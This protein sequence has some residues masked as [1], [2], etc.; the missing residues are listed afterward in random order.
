MIEAMPDL[1]T[2][3]FRTQQ[4]GIALSFAGQDKSLEEG[5]LGRHS[6]FSDVNRERP[7]CGTLLESDRFTMQPDLSCFT[8]LH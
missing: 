6:D 1:F 3:T 4:F 7:E 8:A 2:S 5:V